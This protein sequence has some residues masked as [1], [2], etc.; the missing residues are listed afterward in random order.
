MSS[1]LTFKF[2]RPPR[3]P[4]N[5][6]SDAVEH[7]ISGHSIRETSVKF[8]VSVGTVKRWLKAAGVQAR[9]RRIAN[10]LAYTED[11]RRAHSERLKGRPSGASGKRWKL[12]HIKRNPAIAGANNPQWKGG[13]TPQHLLLRNSPEYRIWREAVF[14]RD[15]WTCVFCGRRSQVGDK[16]VLHADHIQPFA[17]YPELRLDVNNGRT[18]CKDCHK[19]TDTY[20][21]NTRF[22]SGVN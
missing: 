2:L 8:E 16:V 22:K 10:S 3:Y 13:V 1:R 19:T 6:I 5:V 9:E 11:R 4:E 18:L 20:G 12:S 21:V 7:Y 14:E 17:D 15:N